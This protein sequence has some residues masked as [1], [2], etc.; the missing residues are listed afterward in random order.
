MQPSHSPQRQPEQTPE[1]QAA[2]DRFPREHPGW[3]ATPL[4]HGRPGR[5]WAAD[6]HKPLDDQER[7]LRFS[8]E[9]FADSLDELGAAVARERA[10]QE[11]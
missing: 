1:D 3:T 4:P 10:R 8:V 9:L 2:L 6:R 7:E 5:R 11:R